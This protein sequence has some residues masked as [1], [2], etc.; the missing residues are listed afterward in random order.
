MDE[1]SFHNITIFKKKKKPLH[2]ILFDELCFWSYFQ[3]G[4]DVDFYHIY[5]T[6]Q[7]TWKRR[8]GGVYWRVISLDLK[9]KYRKQSD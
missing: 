8:R 5:I 2:Y 7:L 4:A 9:F 6:I 3:F 1:L